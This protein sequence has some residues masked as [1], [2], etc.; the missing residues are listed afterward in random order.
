MWDA[1]LW[2]SKWHH[3]HWMTLYLCGLYHLCVILSY[4]VVLVCVVV[5]E[6]WIRGRYVGIIYYQFDTNNNMW[7]LVFLSH[8]VAMYL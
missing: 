1:L 7:L 6:D 5:N 8:Y 2:C 4:A 3:K